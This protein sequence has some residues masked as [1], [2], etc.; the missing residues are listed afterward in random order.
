MP[1]G[2]IR[3]PNLGFDSTTTVLAQPQGQSEPKDVSDLRKAAELGD[4]QKQYELG[5]RY[6]T[7]RGVVKDQTEAMRWW[8]KAAEQGDAEMQRR[9]AFQYWLDGNNVEAAKWYL[10]AGEQGSVLAQENLLPEP[11]KEVTHLSIF[12]GRSMKKD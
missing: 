11:F 12:W 1:N 5:N 3:R 7:G 10:K 6:Y 2:E 4:A 9:L 8:R